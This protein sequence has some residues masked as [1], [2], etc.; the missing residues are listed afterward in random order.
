MPAIN[1]ALVLDEGKAKLIEEK[2]ITLGHKISGKKLQDYRNGAIGLC[3]KPLMLKGRVGWDS[4][5]V[6][7]IT[8]ASETPNMNN[9]LAIHDN[10]SNMHDNRHDIPKV[11]CLARPG[12]KACTTSN[13]TAIQLVD[14]DRQIKCEPCGKHVKAKAWTCRCNIPWHLCSVHRHSHSMCS[15]QNLPM[16]VPTR[17]S[18]RI[19]TMTIEDLR[20][21]DN[22]RTRRGPPAIL[23]PQCNILSPGLREKFAHLLT[24]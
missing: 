12:C 24:R 10:M 4:K 2:L 8:N 9:M 16:R 18:K 23:P 6:K 5:L 1:L 7:S 13:N 11:V 15:T 3:S 21:L 17:G 19:P 20:A 22:R 14:L